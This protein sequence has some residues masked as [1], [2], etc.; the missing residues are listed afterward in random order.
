MLEK[1]NHPATIAL[2]G[3]SHANH[4]Y[5]GLSHFNNKKKQNL[6]LLAGSG[7]FP[8]FNTESAMIGVKDRCQELM[9]KSLNYAMSDPNIKTIILTNYSNSGTI[10]APP[11]LSQKS[12]YSRQYIKFS[13]A[14]PNANN[15]E[16]YRLAMTSM[17]HRLVKSNKKII[18]IL[19]VPDIE[20]D[21]KLCADVRPWHITN[22]LKSPC[23]IR[24]QEYENHNAIYLSVTKSV[25]KSFPNVK[26]LEPSKYLCDNKYCWAMRKNEILYRDPNH[27]SYNGSL[28]VGKKIA[29][30][31]AEFD[32]AQ[33]SKSI[34]NKT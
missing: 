10:L 16:I 25:L 7:C 13:G 19:D 27:L 33:K 17:L 28:F 26:V 32:R 12:S 14:P 30:E 31:L 20:F 4:I 21:P 6:L 29:F 5:W 15:S 24:R 8:F 23:A 2:I 34:P 18:F 3:D 11:S 9:N 22:R 1:P